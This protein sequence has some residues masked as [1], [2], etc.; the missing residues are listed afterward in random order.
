MFSPDGTE[1]WDFILGEK[2]DYIYAGEN[3]AKNF[4][5]FDDVVEAWYNSPSHKENLLNKNY[6]EM[7][8]AIVNGELNGYE[9][10]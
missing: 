3:L 6:T 5:T 2:Y 10:T 7:G 9:T 8:F 1:P 4:S